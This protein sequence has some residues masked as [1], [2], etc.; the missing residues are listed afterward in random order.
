MTEMNTAVTGPGSRAR[1]LRLP[2]LLAALLAL[3]TG[4][5]GPMTYIHPTAD[6]SHI[7]R[8]AV[9]PIQN[10]TEEKNSEWKVMNVLTTELLR[11]GVAVVEY[12]EVAKVLRS[13]GQGKEE[14]SLNKAVCETAGKRLGVQGFITGAV[15]EYGFSQGSGDSYPEVS[16][17]LKLIDA[18]S[19]EILWEASHTVKGTTVM[20]RLFGVS[21]KSP[22]DLCEEAVVEMLATLFG[23]RGWLW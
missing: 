9:V 6:M 22:S 12:G 17:S 3:L 18:A 23:R 5:A 4:C 14:G 10:L 8:V 7:K 15:H 11:S 21:K 16:I 13:E 20:D 1:R 2:L 19:F